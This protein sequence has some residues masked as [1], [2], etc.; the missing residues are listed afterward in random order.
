MSTDGA[1][2]RTRETRST[3]DS[4]ELLRRV[5]GGDR[6]AAERLFARYWPQLH[7]WAHRRMPR[8]ARS[9]LDTADVVQDAV[10]QGFR[11]VASFEPQHDGAMLR[12]LRRTLLNR[13]RDQFRYAAR[14]PP[15]L[16]LEDCHSDTAASP[17]ESTADEETRTRYQRAL[18]RLRPADRTAIVAR[19]DL[20]YSYEQLALVLHK[21]TAEAARLAARRALLRLAR[22]MN[23][24]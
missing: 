8:W 13:I 19:V 15:P 4:R 3:L 2:R 10:L 6:E 9:G 24:G 14:H 11:H 12:Y 1:D 17:F 23:N 21:P 7:R 16:P 18:T 20:G 22:E 5:H